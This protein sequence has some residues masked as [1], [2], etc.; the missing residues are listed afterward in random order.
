MHIYVT[1]YSKFNKIHNIY[2]YVQKLSYVCNYIAFNIVYY[3]NRL[4]KSESKFNFAI[5]IISHFHF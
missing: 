5:I 2:R 3:T 4:Q 1:T